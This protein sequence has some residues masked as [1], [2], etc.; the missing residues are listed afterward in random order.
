MVNHMKL[1][2]I[3]LAAALLC[4][5]SF[6]F[7]QQAPIALGPVGAGAPAI[8]GNVPTT[9]QFIAGYGAITT[10]STA[11]NYYFGSMFISSSEGLATLL[12]PRPG[13]FKNFYAVVNSAPGGTATF[14]FTL[15]VNGASP[16]SGPTCT[17]TGSATTCSDTTHTATITAGQTY[18]VLLATSAAA[19]STIPLASVEFDQ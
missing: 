7:A 14:V 17:I 8:Y 15:R 2:R 13:T 16:S 6:A 4:I 5:G 11:A 18:D 9:V 19:A 1:A 10:A 12:S 3:A